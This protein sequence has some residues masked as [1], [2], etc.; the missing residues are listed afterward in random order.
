MVHP[1][2]FR[3][4]VSGRRRGVGASMLRGLLRLAESPYTAAARWRNRRYDDGRA[5]VLRVP[6][7]VVSVGNLTVGGTGKTP[8]VRWTAQW[9]VDRGVR[10]ALV[11]RGYRAE[12]GAPNDEARELAQLLPDV[13]HVQDADR[14]A[15]AR[16]AIDQF[17]CQVVLLDDGFQ[18]RRLARDLDVVLLDALE[19]FGYEHLVPRGTLR[20]PVEGLRR[21]G[22]VC[23]SRADLLDALQRDGIRQRVSQLAPA[24]AWCELVHAPSRLLNLAG[25]SEPLCVLSGRRV[26]AFCGIGNPAGFRHTL[27]AVGCDVVLWREFPDHHAYRERDL[28]DLSRA[29]T[30]SG[31]EMLVCTHKDLVKLPHPW[32]ERPLWAVLVEIEVRAGRE[33]LERALAGAARLDER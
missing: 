26:A 27:A 31:A 11:S 1:T 7:P 10:V 2:A 29:A 15:G 23:L 8:L 25:A 3:D 28:A 17:A 21:A 5:E 13:P 30:A 12:G 6:V 32:G 4:L 19:P 33:A 9:L 18:H 20:E 14:V 24:A 16:R 22:V